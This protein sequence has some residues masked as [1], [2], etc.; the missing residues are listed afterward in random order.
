[1]VLYSLPPP[2]PPTSQDAALKRELTGVRNERDNYQYRVNL[3]ADQLQQCK[4][5]REEE[6]KL[7]VDCEDRA[8]ELSQKLVRGASPHDVCVCV[9]GTIDIHVDTHTCC[10]LYVHCT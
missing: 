8:A 5:G 9:R 6:E 1:M 3:L 4:T 2:P 7:V 10:N